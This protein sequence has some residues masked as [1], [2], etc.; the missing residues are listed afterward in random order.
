M[1]TN[2]A[3]IIKSHCNACLADTNHDVIAEHER[4]ETT[5]FRGETHFVE[6]DFYQLVT[7]RGCDNVTLRV[8]SRVAGGE[9]EVSYFP[10]AISRKQP[11]WLSFPR[12]P[13]L[14][15]PHRELRELFREVYSTLHCGNNR[16]A[17]MGTRA[18]VD[19]ALTDKL[20]DIGG[21]DRKLLVA[22]GKGWIGDVQ[23]K[24]LAAAVEAGNAASHR[25]YK[26]ESEQLNLVLDIVEHLIELL[27][28]LERSAGKLAQ[29]TPARHKVKP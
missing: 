18:I 14:G 19:L 6:S 9:P 28:V 27:Y 8:T 10:P 29:E 20:G 17:L 5:E 4:E 11:K 26:P 1:T 3:K 16:L 12:W 2:A 13:L 7:C 22:R 23:H 21:F 24:T 25:A 15:S